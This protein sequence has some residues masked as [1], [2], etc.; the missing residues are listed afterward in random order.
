MPTTVSNVAAVGESLCRS[1]FHIQPP[2]VTGSLFIC[3]LLTL[4]ALLTMCEH[5]KYHTT[6]SFPSTQILHL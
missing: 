1:Y 5:M 3:L 2:T 6:K 4:S